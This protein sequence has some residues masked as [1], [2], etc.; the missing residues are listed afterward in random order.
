MDKYAR[1]AE[2]T[3]LIREEKL[4]LQ[5]IGARFKISR[6]RVRQILATHGVWER[7]GNRPAKVYTFICPQCK[8]EFQRKRRHVKY[9]SKKCH[10]LFL[11]KDRPHRRDYATQKEYNNARTKWYYH[12]VLKHRPDFKEIIKRHNDAA[13]AKQKTKHHE[14]PRT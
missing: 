8:T 5:E 10:Y 9:C 1:A 14:N 2:M 11:E 13:Y 7:T 3:R 6:E 12:N 4:T